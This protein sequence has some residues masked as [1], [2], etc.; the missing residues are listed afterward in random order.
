[1][2][3]QNQKQNIKKKRKKKKHEAADH[4]LNGLTTQ[5]TIFSTINEKLFICSPYKN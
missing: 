3:K 5:A 1:M 2:L 4:H